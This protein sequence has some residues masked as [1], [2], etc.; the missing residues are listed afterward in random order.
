VGDAADKLA[1]SAS[2]LGNSDETYALVGKIF[3]WT[4][5]MPIAVIVSGKFLSSV[6]PMANGKSQLFK[7]SLKILVIQ[8]NNDEV[9][10][11]FAGF[12]ITLVVVALTGGANFYHFTA[13]R[14]GVD[15]GQFNTLCFASALFCVVWSAF[16]WL[17]GQLTTSKSQIKIRCRKC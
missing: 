9:T 11:G 5:L 14:F 3:S 7:I 15:P 16:I 12:M 4:L 10:L 17:W 13:Q 6:F 1:Q 8:A 2:A